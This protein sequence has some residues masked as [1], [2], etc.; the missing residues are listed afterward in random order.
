[1]IEH[2]RGGSIF[3]EN[4]MPTLAN[5]PSIFC[6]TPLAAQQTPWAQASGEP[7]SWVAGV[8]V[9]H[10]GEREYC[11]SGS[12]RQMQARVNIQPARLVKAR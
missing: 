1:M 2:E 4:R 9:A 8:G 11:S 10:P 7:S 3:I 12:S 6:K 5:N